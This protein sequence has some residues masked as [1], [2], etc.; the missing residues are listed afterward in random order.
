LTSASEI[1]DGGD[2]LV[3][4]VF[5]AD[6]VIFSRFAYESILIEEIRWKSDSC[7]V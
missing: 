2:F 1:I 6:F 7:L 3:I 5:D 4:E